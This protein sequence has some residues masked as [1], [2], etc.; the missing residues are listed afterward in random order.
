M[1][2]GI[3]SQLGQEVLRMIRN[4]DCRDDETLQASAELIRI[5]EIRAAEVY[6]ANARKTLLDA[7]ERHSAAVLATP[8]EYIDALKRYY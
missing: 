6:L 8:E 3:Y 7:S 1:K 4:T 2:V 5:H